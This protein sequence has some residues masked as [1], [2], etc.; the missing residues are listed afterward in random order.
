MCA[1]TE[2]ADI[3]DDPDTETVTVV[4]AKKKS[5]SFDQIIISSGHEWPRKHEGKIA[6][7]F[8]RLI[9]PIRSGRK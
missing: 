6:N 5:I 7:Y 3:I 8:T 9:H 2:V 1:N 4:T